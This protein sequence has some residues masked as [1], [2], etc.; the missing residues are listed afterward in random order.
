MLPSG[1][2]ALPSVEICFGYSTGVPSTGQ[3][4]GR[5]PF[6]SQWLLQR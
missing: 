2:G 3:G 1:D 6:V 5:F 4:H